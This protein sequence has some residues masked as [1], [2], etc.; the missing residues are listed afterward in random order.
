ASNLF[1]KHMKPRKNGFYK[2]GIVDP[3]Q[4]RKYADS[5]KSDPI[6][7]RSGLEL[8]FIQY[9]ENNS[10]IIR[11]ASEPI[12]IPYYSRLDKKECNYYPDYI[13]ENKQGNKV[14]VEVKPYNQTLKPDLTDTSWL[15]EQWI[16]NIDKWTAAKKFA[17]D[18]DMKFI[19]VTE[20]FFM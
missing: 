3:K 20:K 14:I 15:K 10:N 17:E 11:W 13:L 9:C 8:Q 2:Q 5:C 16:K 12:K 6:I 1:I 19:I 18:H 4:C 7:Y